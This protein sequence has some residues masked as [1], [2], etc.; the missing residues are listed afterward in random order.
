M[1]QYTTAMWT[2]LVMKT[3]LPTAS[4][5]SGQQTVITLR[6]LGCHVEYVSV[7]H[8]VKRTSLA[9]LIPLLVYCDAVNTGGYSWTR[10]EGG[11]YVEYNC[12]NKPGHYVRRKCSPEGAWIAMD[13]SDCRTCKPQILISSAHQNI[14]QYS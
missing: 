3:V 2:V 7:L 13:T 12:S 10:T 8:R 4:P 9:H 5:H 11:Q 1:V 6:M 14:L